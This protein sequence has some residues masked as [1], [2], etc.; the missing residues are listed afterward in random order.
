ME[1]AV[2]NQD[3]VSEV[4]DFTDDRAAHIEA[5]AKSV[6]EAQAEDMVPLPQEGA[7]E[8]GPA[9]DEGEEPEETAEEPDEPEA[10]GD[11]AEE[12][13]PAE[14]EPEPPAKT[15]KAKHSFRLFR[16]QRHAVVGTLD[17]VAALVHQQLNL[18]VGLH[19]FRHHLEAEYV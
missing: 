5:M 4:E 10:P 16:R 19:P 1:E 17:L 9:E 18:L 15:Y 11:E 14:E 12:E 6:E 2:Q 13:E 3:E 7:Y 8:P